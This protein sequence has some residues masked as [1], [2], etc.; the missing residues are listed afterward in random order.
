[1]RTSGHRLVVCVLAASLVGLVAACGGNAAK[2]APPTPQPTPVIT[3]DPHLHDPA[4]ADA[5]FNVLRSVGLPLT[6]NNATNGQASAPI[7]KRINA[8]IGGWPLLITQFRTSALLRSVT[9]WDAAKPPLQGN[10]PY[11]FVGLNILVEFGPTANGLA[12]P[13]GTRVQQ[14]ETLVAVLDPLLSPLEQRSVSPVTVAKNGPP[15]ASLPATP[16]AAASHAP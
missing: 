9:K 10:P 13:D 15:P 14:A 5:V 11:A 16:S 3:P 2:S 7:V 8:N 6:V 1:M 4:T 12:R